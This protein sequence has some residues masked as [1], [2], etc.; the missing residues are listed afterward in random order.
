M[1]VAPALGAAQLERLRQA[2]ASGHVGAIDACRAWERWRETPRSQKLSKRHARR[3][4]ER[5]A[6]RALEA[7]GE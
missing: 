4:F 2:A 7:L 3:A 5:T 6:Q 1:S